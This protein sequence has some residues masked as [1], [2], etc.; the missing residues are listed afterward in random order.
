[1]IFTFFQYS[2]LLGYTQIDFY[3]PRNIKKEFTNEVFIKT[4]IDNMDVLEEV[5]FE[6]LVD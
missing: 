1:M 2:G 3:Y 4:Q 5:R 6:L